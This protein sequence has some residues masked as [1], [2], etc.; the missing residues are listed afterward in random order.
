MLCVDNGRGEG[1]HVLDTRGLRIKLADDYAAPP[2]VG[3]VCGNGTSDQ[4]RK[5]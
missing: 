3:I 1:E 5:L 4:D 2:K